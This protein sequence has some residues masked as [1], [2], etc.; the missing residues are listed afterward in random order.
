M[1]KSISSRAIAG[2]PYPLVK[3]PRVALEHPAPPFDVNVKFAKSIALPVDENSHLPITLCESPADGDSP[4]APN[5]LVL[6]ATIPLLPV[7]L[8]IG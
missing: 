2:A 7:P 6:L 4:P 1:K 3:I 8:L 5:P